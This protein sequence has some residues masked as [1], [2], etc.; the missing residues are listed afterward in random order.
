M[1]KSSIH[2]RDNRNLW[3]RRRARRGRSWREKRGG[4]SKKEEERE[5]GKEGGTKGGEPGIWNQQS[6]YLI[7]WESDTGTSTFLSF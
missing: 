7:H 6:T 2:S 3:N 5:G 4:K 1:S